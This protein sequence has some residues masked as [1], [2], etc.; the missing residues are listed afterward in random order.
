MQLQGHSKSGKMIVTR[1]S[2]N[3]LNVD[4][5]FFF[6]EVTSQSLGAVMLVLI[7]M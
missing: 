3:F 4:V 1:D 5:C 7:N 6:T 2:H